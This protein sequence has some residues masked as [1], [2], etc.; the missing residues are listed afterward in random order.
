MVSLV[1]VDGTVNVP[2]IE[3]NTLDLR[4][5]RFTPLVQS[6][7]KLWR[8]TGPVDPVRVAFT[9]VDKRDLVPVENF[10]PIRKVRTQHSCGYYGF[11]KPSQAEVLAQLPPDLDPE[12]NAFYII[13]EVYAT[14]EKAETDEDDIYLF[15]D[16]SGHI[17]TTVFGRIG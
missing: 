7:G 6:N 3:D 9:M 1:S 5:R 13:T 8:L 16:G 11:F 4:V 12:A 15:R 17:A 14:G 2:H 10:Q